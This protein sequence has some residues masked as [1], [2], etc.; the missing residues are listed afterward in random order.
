MK[1]YTNY[2]SLKP[3][4]PW[5]QG[6]SSFYFLNL[7]KKITVNFGFTFSLAQG[8]IYIKGAQV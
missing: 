3:I 2:E 4:H 5:D 8:W 6:S 1:C 7:E